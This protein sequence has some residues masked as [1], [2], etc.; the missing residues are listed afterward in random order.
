[1]NS[2]LQDFRFGL[3]M[4]RKNPGFALAAILTLALG[5]ASNTA[6]FTITSAVLLRSL[7]YQ[8][9]QKLVVADPHRKDGHL[10]GFTLNRFDLVR[11]RNRSFSAIGVVASDSFNLTRLGEPQQ[12]VGARVSPGF[13]LLLEIKPPPLT[14]VLPYQ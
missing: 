14:L 3:H 5:I 8:G 12:I 9:P 7:P 6:I 13:F 1:M 10:Y 11:E 2:F 4:L